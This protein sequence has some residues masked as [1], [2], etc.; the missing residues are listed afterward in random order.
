[1]QSESVP[2]QKLSKLG[3]KS[4]ESLR[5]SGKDI[6]YFHT[7]MIF[8]TSAMFNS[9]IRL[10]PTSCQVPCFLGNLVSL[11]LHQIRAQDYSN[12]KNVFKSVES[13]QSHKRYPDLE[14]GGLDHS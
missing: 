9:C 3:A 14:K 12:I 2:G 6:S 1:M 11:Y 4:S 5:S 8:L 7:F 13:G 10:C